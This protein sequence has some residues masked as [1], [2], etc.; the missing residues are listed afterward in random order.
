MNKIIPSRGPLF[1]RELAV[2]KMDGDGMYEMILA[3]SARARE[4]RRQNKA[5]LKDEFTNPIVTALLELQ[6]DKI[7]GPEYFK[8]VS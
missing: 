8:K 5:S 1:D 6:N 7:S 4:I 3:M 2:S